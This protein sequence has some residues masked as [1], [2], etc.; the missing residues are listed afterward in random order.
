VARERRREL[1][2]EHNSSSTDDR[3]AKDLE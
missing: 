1:D 2:Q 3:Y